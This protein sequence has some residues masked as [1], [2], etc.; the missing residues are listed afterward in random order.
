M[1]MSKHVND[2][3]SPH[4]QQQEDETLAKAWQIDL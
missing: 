1:N 3:S 4:Q 2:S